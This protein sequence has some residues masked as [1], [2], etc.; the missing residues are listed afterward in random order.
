[1][2][3][4][5]EHAYQFHFSDEEKVKI[6]RDVSGALRAMEA[7]NAIKEALGELFP[8]QGMVSAEIYEEAKDALRQMKEQV[9]EEFAHNEEQREL[10]REQWPFDD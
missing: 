5:G 6:E 3:A 2:R 9:I 10:W 8:V 1:V 7:I 4:R